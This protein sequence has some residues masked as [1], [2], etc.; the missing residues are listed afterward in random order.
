MRKVRFPVVS[1]VLYV[2]AGLF[3]L[4]TIW[5]AIYSFNTISEAVAAGQ[6]VISGSEFE[7]A[8]FLMNNVAQYVFFAIALFALG[9]IVQVVSFE[10]DEDEYEDVD[11]DADEDPSFE[12]IADEDAD[13]ADHEALE[14]N[15]NE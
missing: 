15:N 10:A 9:W 3:A 13:E 12:E 4:Y 2:F 11:A 6:L 14:Q 1:I 8:N 7:V 5:A